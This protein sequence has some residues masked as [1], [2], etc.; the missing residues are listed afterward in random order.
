MTVTCVSVTSGNAST[1]RRLKAITPA[2][3]NRITPSTMNSGWYSANE[4]MRLITGWRL[5]FLRQQ[6]LEQ[7]AAFDDDF[8]VGR[9]P[10]QHDLAAVAR[11]RPE[12][13]GL[14]QVATI[15]GVH[16]HVVLLAAQ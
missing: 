7:Q 3:T 10:F 6:P 13:D 1:G 8:F 14:A 2:P 11:G 4:T 16:E 5:I 12:L 9:E 15:A